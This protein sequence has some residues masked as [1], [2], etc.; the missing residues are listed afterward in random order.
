MADAAVTVKYAFAPIDLVHYVDG[1]RESRKVQLK[2]AMNAEMTAVVRE[3]A[4]PALIEAAIASAYGAGQPTTGAPSGSVRSYP[5]LQWCFACLTDARASA[6]QPDE[7]IDKFQKK[8]EVFRRLFSS[9]S[10]EFRK[11]SDT[12]TDAE[13]YGMLAVVLASRFHRTGNYNDLNTVLKLNDALLQSGWDVAPAYRQLVILS[14]AFE[15]CLLGS[16]HAA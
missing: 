12:W 2:T 11:N 15:H 10:A 16:L 1:F 5:L 4:T 13:V 9:Y 3:F 14:V 8:F 6:L 7:I